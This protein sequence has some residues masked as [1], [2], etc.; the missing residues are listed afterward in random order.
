MKIRLDQLVVENGLAESREQAKR[1]ILAGCVL[2]KNGTTLTKAGVSVDS[3]LEIHLKETLPYVSRGGLK[4]EGFFKEHPIQVKDFVCLDIGSSTGGFTD[5]LLQNGARRVVCID[6]G[7]GILH[8][9]LRQDPRVE[10]HEKVNAR[11]LT[12]E[13]AG[14]PFDL[15]VA[16][17]SFIS[18]KLVLPPAASLLKPG[19][20]A[21]VLV[22][23]QFEAGRE[24]VEKGG[25]VRS[26]DVQR[27]CVESIQTFGITLGWR[28][29][30]QA[31]CVLK[32]PAGNQEYFVHFIK[33]TTDADTKLL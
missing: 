10:L 11:E 17:V 1:L 14:G 5:F 24:H 32:G 8:W 30:G 31:P 21:L 25:V 16:D 22:K 9:K 26:S 6:V 7:T 15:L 2:D 12:R 18:L 33:E 27:S 29:L 3:L 20:Q 19:G 13:I 4:I 28:P 23:P